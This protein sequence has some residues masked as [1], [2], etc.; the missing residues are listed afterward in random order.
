M[1][2]KRAKLAPA[3]GLKGEYGDWTKLAPASGSR[4]NTAG[5]V[6]P[7]E[8]PRDGF[9]HCTGEATESRRRWGTRGVTGPAAYDRT[10]GYR[11]AP[12]LMINA[13]FLVQSTS[14]P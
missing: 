6:T 4:A 13:P 14:S 8:P 1:G 11:R 10:M 2:S 3:L 5:S 9:G 12:G 7:R